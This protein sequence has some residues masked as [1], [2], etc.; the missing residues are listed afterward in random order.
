M[1]GMALVTLLQVYLFQ[2]ATWGDDAIL[3]LRYYSP[4][5]LQMN[6]LYWVFIIFGLGASVSR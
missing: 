5:A 4:I 3:L 6:R 2:V 1:G